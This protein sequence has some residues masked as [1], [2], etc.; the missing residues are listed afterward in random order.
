MLSIKLPYYYYFYYYYYVLLRTISM[1]MKDKVWRCLSSIHIHSYVTNVLQMC[2]QGQTVY[3]LRCCLQILSRPKSEY[4]P[5]RSRGVSNRYIIHLI[6][7]K[8]NLSRI[9]IYV[10]IIN[11]GNQNTQEKITDLLLVVGEL[12]IIK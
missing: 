8:T 7:T 4:V 5:I 3:R 2:L 9:D 1:T 11:C 6:I 12:Y 10:F